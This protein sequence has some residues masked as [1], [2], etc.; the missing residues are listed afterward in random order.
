MEKVS[1][2]IADG[3]YFQCR[4]IFAHFSSGWELYA[5]CLL[6]SLPS[7]LVW[8]T[9]MIN[10]DLTIINNQVK[11]RCSSVVMWC[12]GL[13]IL[14]YKVEEAWRTT[15]TSF[16]LTLKS[17]AESV[18]SVHPNE[19]KEVIIHSSIEIHS[20]CRGTYCVKYI[21][22]WMRNFDSGKKT[23]CIYKEILPGADTY[24]PS[25]VSLASSVTSS[26]QDSVTISSIAL[27]KKTF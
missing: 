2:F 15:R 27:L 7:K 14:M 17:M 9:Y 25:Q 24:K 6:W 8:S 5:C 10:R 13:Y 18:H 19:C 3:W 26:L 12:Q 22:D 16:C 4:W 21:M 11:N 1:Y 23:P 20:M